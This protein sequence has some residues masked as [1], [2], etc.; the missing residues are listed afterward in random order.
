MSEEKAAGHADG[1]YVRESLLCALTPV[2][3]TLT[4]QSE[5]SR[6]RT[7][8]LLA[9]HLLLTCPRRYDLSGKTYVLK[10][11]KSG[12][13]GEKCFLLLES[14]SRFHTTEVRRI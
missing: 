8:S 3:C 2:Q 4:P 7:S 14:G 11:S 12:G 5:H 1:Q 10:M 9:A 13:E 6:L